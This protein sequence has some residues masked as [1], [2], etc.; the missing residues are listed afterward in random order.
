MNEHQGN[1]Q[2]LPGETTD[3]IKTSCSQ[4]QP[5]DDHATKIDK[6]TGKW[7]RAWPILIV[8]SFFVPFFAIK[9]SL[10]MLI[11]FFAPTDPTIYIVYMAFFTLYAWV[12]SK[13]MDFF[14]VISLQIV[15]KLCPQLKTAA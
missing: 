12:V 15:L 9:A 2:R 13:L 1:Q 7:N 3:E 8:S 5:A 10:P 4:T 6:V 11:N 14:F